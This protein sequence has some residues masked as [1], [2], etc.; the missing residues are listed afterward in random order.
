MRAEQAF[1]PIVDGNDLFAVD[2]GRADQS[3]FVFECKGHL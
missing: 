2:N 3:Y 1:V